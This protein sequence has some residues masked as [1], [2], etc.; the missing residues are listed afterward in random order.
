VL[1]IQSTIL[2][3]QPR[4]GKQLRSYIVTQKG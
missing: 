1:D 2:R 4:A 3:G